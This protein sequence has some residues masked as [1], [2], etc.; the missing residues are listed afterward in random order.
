LQ[1][2]A[3]LRGMPN[4]PKPTRRVV[5]S[6]M[7]ETTIEAVTWIAGYTN[8]NNSVIVDALVC[9]KLGIDHPHTFTISQATTRWKRD[10]A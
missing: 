8:L 10:H 6:R 1:I 5:W 4:Q 3:T 2:L 7:N 9:A